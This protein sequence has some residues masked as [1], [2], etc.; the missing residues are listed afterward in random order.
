MNAINRVTCTFLV[1]VFAG[2]QDTE[3]APVYP[4]PHGTAT[5][6]DSAIYFSQTQSYRSLREFSFARSSVVPFLG[7]M[8]DT[9]CDLIAT[10]MVNGQTNTARSLLLSPGDTLNRPPFY[11]ICFSSSSQDAATAF[12]NLMVAPESGYVIVADT[13]LT[14]QVWVIQTQSRKFAKILIRAVTFTPLTVQA[15]SDTFST[16][17]TFEWVFQPNG[18]RSFKP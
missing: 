5:I 4:L 13:I 17:V 7:N 2:C 16:E 12:Q 8:F 9:S 6:S 10:F 3:V 11:L 14:N 15:P 18:S 1:L